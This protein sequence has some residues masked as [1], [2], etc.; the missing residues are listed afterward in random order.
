[1]HSSL[2]G[3]LESNL[4]KQSRPN[5]T[6]MLHGFEHNYW[7]A[8]DE[9]AALTEFLWGGDFDALADMPIGTELNNG[10]ASFQRNRV[11]MDSD[12]AT[13]PPIQSIQKAWYTY[14]GDRLNEANRDDAITRNDGS[15]YEDTN[16]SPTFIDE[17]LRVRINN[18]LRVNMASTESCPSTEYMVRSRSTLQLRRQLESDVMQNTCL[19]AYFEHFQ[20]VVCYGCPLRSILI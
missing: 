17:E 8:E 6:S 7:V 11:S 19:C 4:P 9:F 12:N 20:S 2:D 15:R 1:M 13:L 14:L 16:N 10:S 3:S 18:S 5:P